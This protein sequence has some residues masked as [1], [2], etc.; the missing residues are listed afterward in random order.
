MPGGRRPLYRHSYCEAAVGFRTMGA[1][2][3][4][5]G[6]SA[7]TLCRWTRTYPEFA[8]AA[9]AMTGRP[10]GSLYREDY[11]RAVAGF[12]TLTAFA[13]HI[14]VSRGAIYQWIRI[15]PEF[16]EATK[17]MTRQHPNLLYREAY[18]DDIIDFLTNGHSLAAFAGHI[19]VSRD[20]LY[21]WMKTQPEFAE[22][23]KR[24]QA[25]SILW[26]ERRILELAQTG[27]GSA[28]AITFGLKNRAPEE[29][30][31]K[32]HAEVSGT[33]ERI[34]RI[35]RVI[36]RSGR[37]EPVVGYGERSAP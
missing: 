23:V 12:R 9:A 6:V 1:F 8:A 22:A 2:A 13:R 30:R 26:W 14:G 7:R 3:R 35:E 18:C 34:H 29:W 10:S 28:A 19:G 33:V 37:S 17:T 16:A 20:T 27:Q 32:V 21:E 24:A 11:C 36:V 31:D 25:K 4:H 5:I 15:Y